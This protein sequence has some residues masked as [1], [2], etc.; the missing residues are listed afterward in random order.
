VEGK[1]INLLAPDGANHEGES[2]KSGFEVLEVIALAAALVVCATT[3]HSQAK[4]ATSDAAKPALEAPQP[5]PEMDRLRFLL[6]TWD[7]SAEY[8]KSPMAPQGGRAPGWYKAQLGPGGFS[9]VADFEADGPFG[10]EIGH[11]VLSWDPKLKSYTTVTVGNNF[12]GVIVGHAQWDGENLI[13]KSEFDMEGVNVGMRATYSRIQEKST[14][15][16][17]MV[18]VGDGPFVLLYSGD[19]TKK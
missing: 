16:E 6:G 10:K 3:A 5:G 19:A 18:R 8:A 11:Q 12:P 15:M 7:V 14:H 9:I 4:S 13:T 17:E 1:E 2:M